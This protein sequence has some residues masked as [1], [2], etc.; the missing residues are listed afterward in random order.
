MN[1]WFTSNL[2]DAMLAGEASEH[3][4]AL[5]SSVH[6][7]AN[8]P[9]EMAIFFRHESEGHLHCEVKV[10]FSP[11]TVAVARAVDAI[12]CKKPSANGLGLL[13]GAEE[14]WPILFPMSKDGER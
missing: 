9:K 2:G 12:P 7:I 11:A 6:Q 5:F 8:S 14:S 10:Y 13:A 3:I 4:K 1:T